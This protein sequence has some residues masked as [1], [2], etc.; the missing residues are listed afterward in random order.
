MGM[1]RGRNLGWLLLLL[2]IIVFLF[3]L[4]SPESLE[5]LKENRVF[6]TALGIFG[7]LLILLLFIKLLGQPPGLPKRRILTVL[8]C[9][10]CEVTSIREFK[11]GD[12]IP[13]REGKCPSCEGEMFIEAIYPEEEGK[14]RKTTPF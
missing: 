3:L 8:K 5:N 12:Y 6:S 10:K 11:R 13:K 1:E 9:E 14:K 4:S 2:L 7:L